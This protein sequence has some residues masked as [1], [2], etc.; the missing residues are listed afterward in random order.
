[1]KTLW[2]PMQQGGD[3]SVETMLLLLQQQQQEHQAQPWPTLAVRLDRIARLQRMLEHSTDMFVQA[4]SEDFGHRATAE[5]R[6]AEVAYLQSEIRHVQR[7][8]KAWMCPRR[9][10]TA[11]AFWPGSNRLLRQPLGVVGIV[12]AWNYP[13]QLAL[14]PALGALAAGNRVMIK[15]S[16]HAPGLAQ[17]LRQAVARYFAPGE[18]VVLPGD[19]EMGKL[20]VQLPFDHLVFTGSTAVGRQVAQAAAR[21]LT[22]VTLELGGKSPVLIDRS[23]NV[24]LAARRI[25]YAKLLNAGQT[26]VAPDYVL[27]HRSQHDAFV[28]AYSQAVRS[29][30]PTIADNP[31]Y[32]S[33]IHQGHFNRLLHLLEDA[34]RQ[35]AQIVA[36]GETQ[37]VMRRLAPC[38]VLQLPA[39]AALMQQEIFGPVLPVLVYDNTDQ[40]LAMIRSRAH[41]LALYWFGTD[42]Q[43]QTRVLENTLS[44]SVCINDCLFQLAQHAQPFGGVGESGMG[45]YH[46]E[47]GFLA[48]S[49]EKPV[50]IQ[51]RFSA[52]RWLRP[53]FGAG[54][55][56][57]LRLMRW[58]P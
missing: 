39:H 58:L 8:L 45:A 1:M 9:M 16:E 15:P 23:A 32:T 38:L 51:K 12:A 25:A 44:G 35:G 4:I 54:F 7:H 6:L 49:Q 34:H 43:E 48:F 24:P 26:C 22:P 30:Y 56:R 10:P 28:Q 5:T 40:A 46:G 37:T 27:V 53:P 17:A 41:P 20:F 21:N 29:M 47:R 31:D 57:M 36:L 50:F 3:T 18:M 2:D 55:E 42:R 19:A 13:L 33:I 52:T 14:S 11:L